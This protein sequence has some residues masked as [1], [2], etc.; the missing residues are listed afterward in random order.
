MVRMGRKTLYGL[1]RKRLSKAGPGERVG[2]GWGGDV[3]LHGQPL[4]QR[5]LGSVGGG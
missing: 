3:F 5:L 2:L 4:R 1:D